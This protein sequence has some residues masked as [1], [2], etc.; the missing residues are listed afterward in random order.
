[1][2]KIKSKNRIVVSI[3]GRTHPMMLDKF[4]DKSA[5][6][7]SILSHFSDNVVVIQSYMGEVYAP[8]RGDILIISGSNQSV[9]SMDPWMKDLERSIIESMDYNIPILGICFGHQILAH[10]FGA[11]VVKNQRGREIGSCII[12]LNKEGKESIL[13]RGLNETFY[14]YETHED[15]VINNEAKLIE[16][17]R[18]DY[19]LQA[20]K[21]NDFHYGVQF[22]PE[23]NMELMDIF[24]KINQKDKPIKKEVSNRNI[25]ISNMIFT[26]FFESIK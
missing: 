19:G 2:K 1:M 13:F 22:H 10:T 17:A 11:D 6:F 3:A 24:I 12:N 16:L 15:I 4:C 21:V 14:A 9:I 18:N 5:H 20:F 25:D 26:N 8:Q 7:S 23:F